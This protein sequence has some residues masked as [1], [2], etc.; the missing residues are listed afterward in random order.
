MCVYI[1]IFNW[2][3]RF[4]KNEVRKLPTTKQCQRFQTPASPMT[5]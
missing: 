3:H 1:Y 4:Q 2:V 5:V